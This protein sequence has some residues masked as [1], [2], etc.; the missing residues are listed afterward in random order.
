MHFEHIA[1]KLR[2]LLRS[3]VPE[4]T[5]GDS[6]DHKAIGAKNSFADEGKSRVYSVTLGVV[7]AEGL[8]KRERHFIIENGLGPH[9]PRGRNL[10]VTLSGESHQ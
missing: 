10:P 9:A 5:F 6:R 2:P 8:D 1:A 3:T 4:E 7:R